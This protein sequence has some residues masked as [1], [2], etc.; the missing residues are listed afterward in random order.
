VTLKKGTAVKAVLRYGEE[1]TAYDFK[2]GTLDEM[3]LKT[4]D[5]RV[6]FRVLVDR[7]IREI[8]GGD[9]A[10]FKTAGRRDAGKPLGTISL[11]AEGGNLTLES[12]RVYAMKSAWK[13]R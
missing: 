9:G 10:C 11:T 7:P 5:D 12:F 4:I 3:P 6:T 1:A 2:S 13:D 8:V